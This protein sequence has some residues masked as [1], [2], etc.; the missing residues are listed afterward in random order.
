MAI[1][2]DVWERQWRTRHEA[3]RLLL[4]W[5]KIERSGRRGDRTTYTGRYLANA[6]MLDIVRNAAPERFSMADPSVRY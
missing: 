6:D 5:M 2:R 3:C 4:G 1:D